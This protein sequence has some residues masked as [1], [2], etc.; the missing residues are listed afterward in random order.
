V[1]LKAVMVQ[2]MSSSGE[3]PHA[4]GRLSRCP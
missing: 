3:R 1:I 4:A 2:L